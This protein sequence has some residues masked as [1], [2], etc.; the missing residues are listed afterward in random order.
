MNTYFVVVFEPKQSPFGRYD[1]YLIVADDEEEARRLGL[2]EGRKRW[3]DG[4][5]LD[6]WR[7]DRG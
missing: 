6:V 7:V 2:E 3:P 5:T 4:T 1:T